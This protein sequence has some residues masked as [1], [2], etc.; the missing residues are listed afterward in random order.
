MKLAE[1]LHEYKEINEIYEIARILEI[2]ANQ[3]TY[4][5]EVL[6][7]YTDDNATWKARVY[8]ASENGWNR[9]KGFSSVTGVDNEEVITKALTFLREWQI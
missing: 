3:T 9:I 8:A 6:R 4:R 5:V 1:L 7:C 2:V